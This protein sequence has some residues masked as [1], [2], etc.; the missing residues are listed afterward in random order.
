V[1]A[2]LDIIPAVRE[3]SC[4]KDTELRL[5]SELMKNCRRSDR[6]LGKAIGVS[7]PTV[8]R[9]MKRLEKEGIIQGYIAIPNLA[10]LGMEIIAIVLYKVKNQ[11]ELDANARMQ[12]AKEFA[13][14]YPN[15]IFASS[16][17]GSASDRVGISVHKNYSDYAKFVQ[18]IQEYLE[19]YNIVETFLISTVG[20]KVPRSLSFKTLVDYVRK[21]SHSAR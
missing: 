2:V 18:G 3:E 4:L 21:E 10:K 16:G 19:P 7:Q 17:M 14:K 8:S 20:E 9:M 12:K 15:L 1:S 13:E 5:I 11:S 6:E